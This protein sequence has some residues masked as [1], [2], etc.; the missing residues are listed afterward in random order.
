ML[1]KWAD[2]VTRFF[3]VAALRVFFFVCVD[4]H[5]AALERRSSNTQN[6]NKNWREE[7]N[8]PNQLNSHFLPIYPRTEQE[9]MMIV[10][11]S[12]NVL[13]IAD[14]DVIVWKLMLDIFF[15]FFSLK[16]CFV[17]FILAGMR[18]HW[19]YQDFVTV[20]WSS[21]VVVLWVWNGKLLASNRS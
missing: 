19:N 2:V 5:L 12:W 15:L 16:I 1:G 8:G 10:L 4:H 20:S 6:F 14:N 3:F 21:G 11:D 17:S 18:G 13:I 7:K 9:K